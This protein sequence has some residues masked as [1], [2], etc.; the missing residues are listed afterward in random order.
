[1]TPR[2]L[3]LRRFAFTLFYFNIPLL[4]LLGIWADEARGVTTRWFIVV[5]V[6]E[7]RRGAVSVGKVCGGRRCSGCIS[8]TG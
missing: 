8:I 7:G 2:P 1:M 3:L 6:D 5:F 4:I